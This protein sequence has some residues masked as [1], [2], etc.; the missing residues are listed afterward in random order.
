MTADIPA[1]VL[2]AIDRT[3]G[4]VKQMRGAIAEQ[5]KRAGAQALEVA[6]LVSAVRDLQA[7]NMVPTFDLAG[8]VG[9]SDIMTMG[10]VPL[11]GRPRGAAQRVTNSMLRL[12]SAR[13]FRNAVRRQS[14]AA[15]RKWIQHG[16]GAGMISHHAAH[17]AERGAPGQAE[18]HLVKGGR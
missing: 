13:A 3:L 12:Y 7:R 16:G 9:A 14:G 15:A 10:G 17:R 1:A 8:T 5:D 18:L 11:K 4:I 6:A 2:E